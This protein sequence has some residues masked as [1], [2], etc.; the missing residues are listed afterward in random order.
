MISSRHS[1]VVSTALPATSDWAAA[2][3]FALPELWALVAK[4]CGFVG[5]F[6]LMLVCK[7]AREGAKEW[8]R[9]LPHL[10]LSG[11][12]AGGGRTGQ[13]WRLDLG[14]L[15]WE[16]VAD[17]TNA[18][19]AHACCAV[20]GGI[21]VLGG[22]A[23]VEGQVGHDYNSSAGVEFLAYDSQTGGAVFKTLPPLSCGPI[24]S[25]AVAVD[26]SESERGQVL[27]IGSEHEHGSS[28]AVHL[29]DLETGVCTQQPSL[30]SFEGRGFDVCA[31]ARM[32]DGQIVCVGQTFR[33]L[34]TSSEEE[35][36]DDEGTCEDDDDIVTAQVLEPYDQGDPGE[37]SWRWRALPRTIVRRLSGRACVLSD[38]RFAIFGG[39]VNGAS[40][41]TS[42]CEVLTL[43]GDGER[44]EMLPAMRERREGFA[45][46]AI[47]QCVIVAGG[48]HSR[49]VE[50]YEEALG[51]WRRL[52]CSIPHEKKLYH[53]G[54]ALM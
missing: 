41:T 1:T 14:E 30:L 15:Q 43:D 32:L 3:V 18:R 44:W 17:L 23:A 29:V 45:C 40:V 24:T 9:T 51:L 38:G 39:R 31:A 52:P 11:G 21:V 8:L 48:L 20:R 50:V 12:Y 5:A 6:R 49:T 22:Y 47:G 19:A 10:V 36:E 27:L 13:V 46:A 37:A 34:L 2:F 25:F 42:S 54:S 26:E 53:M 33:S 16:H 4:H 28:S 7:A 35:E